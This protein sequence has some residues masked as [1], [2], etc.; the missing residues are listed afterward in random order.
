MGI[1]VTGV[2]NALEALGWPYGSTEYILAQRELNGFITRYCYLASV[3]LAKEKGAFPLFNKERYCGGKF[4]S[5]LDRDVQELIAR[6]GIR[7]SHLTSIAPCGTISFTADNVSSGIEPVFAAEYER[8]V[9][10]NE[11]KRTIIMRDYGLE[12][13][14]VKP[15]KASE[16]TAREHVDVLCA[17]QDFQDSAVSKTCN[18]ATNIEWREFKGIYTSAWNGGAKGCTTYRPLPP[19]QD[20]RGSVL[21]ELPDASEELVCSIGPDGRPSGP[22]A[23]S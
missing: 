1:G 11:G 17:A 14:G 18:V 3:D 23:D 12:Y 8:D 21:R 4:I 20:V 15:R 10:L 9:I 6:Y 5:T 16:V 2:A 7:N 22:C 13:L 19:D